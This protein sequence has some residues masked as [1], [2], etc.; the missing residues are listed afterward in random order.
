MNITIAHKILRVSPR[1]SQE[2]V[3]ESYKILIKKWHPDKHDTNENHRLLA[4][5]RSKRI[6]QAY[7]FL[8][9]HNSWERRALYSKSKRKREKN[10]NSNSIMNS[11]ITFFQIL[12]ICLGIPFAIFWDHP[13]HNSLFPYLHNENTRPNLQFDE[14][15][16]SI[17]FDRFLHTYDREYS[18]L[19]DSTLVNVFSSN[20]TLQSL[21]DSLF[22][23]FTSAKY[24]LVKLDRNANRILI[25]QLFSDH[26]QK[27][28]QSL[29]IFN[30]YDDSLY[31]LIDI[32]E[33]GTVLNY[34]SMEFYQPITK[35]R[36]FYFCDSCEVSPALS[37]LDYFSHSGPKIRYQ[38][39]NGSLVYSS[40]HRSENDNIINILKFLKTRGVSPTNQLNIDDGTRRAYAEII[41]NH[42]YSNY[43][44]NK[45]RSLFYKYY[46]YRDRHRVWGDIVSKLIL[47]YPI[48]Y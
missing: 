9:T 22:V 8:T 30:H 42:F 10:I 48:K 15:R 27:Y 23:Y 25:I 13:L 46:I 38:L 29:L 6:N 31:Y 16:I 18:L 39:D 34:Q 36:N 3:R 28:Q 44:L 45:S 2:D 35:F 26:D 33:N 14:T 40:T 21:M 11:I 17:S 37:N 12:L 4:E 47:E 43:D 32:L 24:D 5:E 7:R 1:N 20:M 19:K 41:A